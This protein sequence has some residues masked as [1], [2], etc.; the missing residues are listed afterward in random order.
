MDRNNTL[1]YR[2]DCYYRFKFKLATIFHQITEDARIWSV[3]LVPNCEPNLA[4]VLALTSS[5][6][7]IQCFIHDP[8]EKL[9]T[10]PARLSITLSV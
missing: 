8:F 7:L 3:E 2:N 1:S 4:A 6:F 10:G 9:R 5:A